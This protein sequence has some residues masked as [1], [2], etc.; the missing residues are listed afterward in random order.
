MPT[1]S[2]LV[3]TPKG[4]YRKIAQQNW[5]LTDEQ[6]IGMHVHHRIPRSQG[7]TDDPSNL[8]VCSPWFHSYVWHG[9]DAHYPLVRWCSDNGQKGGLVK[10]GP[11]PDHQ[12]KAIS[13]AKTGQSPKWKGKYPS[14]VRPRVKCP[15]C[16]KDCANAGTLKL[17]MKVH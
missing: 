7:G 10:T 13:E 2:T 16:G 3:V 9:N 1:G 8:Y 17:H 15:V 14:M 4:K 12:R 11:M 5:G 6:M